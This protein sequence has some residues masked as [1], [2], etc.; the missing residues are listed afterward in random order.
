MDHSLG[1]NE[2]DH[3]S[4]REQTIIGPKCPNS[5]QVRPPLARDSYFSGYQ[6]SRKSP[7][8]ISYA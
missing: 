1:C 4:R 3:M 2:L 7:Q 5:G 6:S 8:I